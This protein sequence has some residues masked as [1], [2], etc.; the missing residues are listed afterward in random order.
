[1]SNL[2]KKPKIHLLK[3]KKILNLVNFEKNYQNNI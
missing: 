1:M 2:N 3:S